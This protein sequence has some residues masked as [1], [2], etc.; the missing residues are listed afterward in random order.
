MRVRCWW[1]CLLAVLLSVP[2]AAEE[3]FLD[4]SQRV[5]LLMDG[6][7]TGR[8][9]ALYDIWIVPGYRH[10]GRQAGRAAWS[11]GDGLRAL[12]CMAAAG[13]QNGL[14]CFQIK[15]EQLTF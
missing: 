2:A 7:I 11:T 8:D 15:H 4:Q 14:S 5:Q 13:H 3:Y 1:P 9:D 12:A 10:A 6:R